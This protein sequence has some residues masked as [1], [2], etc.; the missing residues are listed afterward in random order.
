MFFIFVSLT[1]FLKC[2]YVVAEKDL[3]LTFMSIFK[4]Y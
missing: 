2:V 3:L 1:H 4:K